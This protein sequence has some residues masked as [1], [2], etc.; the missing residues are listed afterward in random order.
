MRKTL[1]LVLTILSAAFL[2]SC[3]HKA[4][5]P[6][7]VCHLLV[8]CRGYNSG[9]TFLVQD[10]WNPAHDYRDIAQVRDILQKIKEAG[11]NVVSIDFTNP[12]QWEAWDEYGKMLDNI[13]TVCH[14][15]EM[16]FLMF[17]GNPAAWTMKYWNGIAGK[18]WYEYAQ[19]PSYRRYGF[20]DDRP[21]MVVFLPGES[22][23]PLWEN[24][25]DEEKDN[26][27]KF[28]LGTCQ[29]NDPIDPC[30][31]DGWGYRNISESSDGAVR[32][33]SPNSGVPPQDWA[34]VDAA[35]W[36]RRVHWALGAKEYAV[37][38]SY[39]DTCDAIHWGIS[40]ASASQR[41]VHINPSTVNDPFIYYNIVKK[42]LT[43]E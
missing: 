3:G 39:D 40:D 37:I 18:I 31:S 17:I 1:I 5:G 4:S 28:R 19:D 32:F 36:E 25:P 21:L 9:S 41:S 15:K 23:W 6:V 22:F 20:G 7:P 13:V 33:C 16:E 42:A 24:T 34:R 8:C 38:G 29:V 30:P 12:S 2:P 43:G 26:L 35:E 11:I 14:E 10:N 27:K